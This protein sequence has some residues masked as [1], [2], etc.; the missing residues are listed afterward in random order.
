MGALLVSHCRYV[1]D[2]NFI[3]ELV[4]VEMLM[5]TLYILNEETLRQ[6]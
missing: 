4:N 6:H 2:K 1:C 3:S 5:N